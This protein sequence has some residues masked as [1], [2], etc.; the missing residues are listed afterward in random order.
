MATMLL[1]DSIVIIAMVMKIE[2]SNFYVEDFIAPALTSI[3]IG[4]EPWMISQGI[5]LWIW[6]MDIFF[7]E[8]G[9]ITTM[10]ELIVIE[11]L[12]FTTAKQGN[13]V[14]R[15]GDYIKLSCDFPTFNIF[16]ACILHNI[17]F[18]VYLQ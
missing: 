1:L 12:P 10:M 6:Q 11:G 9:L 13:V 3:A 4:L 15:L 14:E 17:W 7:V 5:W 16:Q 18:C 2:E 8:F